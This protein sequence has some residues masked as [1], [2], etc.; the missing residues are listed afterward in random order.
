MTLGEFRKFTEGFSDDVVL[1]VWDN[2][3]GYFE[4]D[5]NAYKNKKLFK[6][7]DSVRYD[8]AKSSDKN[9]VKGIVIY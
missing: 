5:T 6:K 9:C 7:I 2:D 3:Y 4:A 8:D 1:L